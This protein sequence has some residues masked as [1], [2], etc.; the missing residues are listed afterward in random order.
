MQF[1]RECRAYASSLNELVMGGAK[2]TTAAHLLWAQSVLPGDSVVD[3]TCGMGRDALVLA[4]LVGSQGTLH[5]FDIQ[6]EAVLETEKLLRTELKAEV[7]LPCAAHASG[8][9][10][11]C[12][13]PTCA[14]CRGGRQ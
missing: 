11:Q 7:Q 6:K 5:A 12:S 1:I 13:V 9:G 14:C 10:E 8:Q 2:L 4:R 3:A